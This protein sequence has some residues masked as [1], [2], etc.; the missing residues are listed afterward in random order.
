ML[1]TTNMRLEAGLAVLNQ[2][3][4]DGSRAPG[5]SGSWAEL[6]VALSRLAVEGPGSRS[7]QGLRKGIE[8]LAGFQHRVEALLSGWVSELDRVEAEDDQ[9]LGET[10]SRFL[11]EVLLLTP[12]QAYGQL[13]CA[14]R[15]REL[16]ETAHAFGH[17]DLSAAHVSVICRAMEQ[18]RSRP[19]AAEHSESD[20]EAMLLDA[21]RQMDPR[22][23]LRHWRQLHYQLDQEGE[24]QEENQQRQR[25]WLQLRQTWSGSYHLEGELDPEGGTLLKTALQ[26]LLGPRRGDD[27]RSADQ[28]R[29]DALAE[30]ARQ[31][32]DQGDLPASGGARPHLAMTADLATLRLVPGSQAAELDWGLPVAG[33]SARRIACDAE[34]TPIVLDA[35][36]DPMHVGRSR[37]TTPPRLRKALNVRDRHCIVRGCEMP[38][39][40]CDA[41]HLR[42]WLDGGETNL[43]GLVLICRTHH[44]DVH[45]RGYRLVRRLDGE[46]VAIPP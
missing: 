40:F 28:R 18:L 4:Q 43:E 7:P 17:G 10:C 3:S 27:D 30:L 33:E 15:L 25:R 22:S 41:H 6:D 9:P 19:P 37:R 29:A 1:K 20:V 38:P 34:I 11:E 12:S 45:E 36:G 26:S 16:P 23:L 46:L 2:A 24:L 39:Q 35:A 8:R 31:R 32:L 42:S 21:A 14:R 5:L 13:R 44:M